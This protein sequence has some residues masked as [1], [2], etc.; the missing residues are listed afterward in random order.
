MSMI[1]AAS[2]VHRLIAQRFCSTTLFRYLFCRIWMGI[3]RFE[4]SASR[5]ARFAP[6]LSMVAISGAVFRAIEPRGTPLSAAARRRTSQYPAATP[7]PRGSA[8]P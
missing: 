3:F 2:R 5:A 7:S 4:F 1:G 6:L 8:A